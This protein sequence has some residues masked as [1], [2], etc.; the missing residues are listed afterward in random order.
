MANNEGRPPLGERVAKLALVHSVAGVGPQ[1]AGPPAN[2]VGI[3]TIR[4]ILVDAGAQLREL[5]A[6]GNPYAGAALAGLRRD[7]RKPALWYCAE[8]DHGVETK[9]PDVQDG[10]APCGFCLGRFAVAGAGTPQFALALRVVAERRVG[11]ARAAVIIDLEI[12]AENEQAARRSHLKLLAPFTEETTGRPAGE[13]EVEP[14]V[15]AAP[16]REKTT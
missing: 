6:E 16:Q 2:H 10:S 14:S 9:P 13:E 7:A 5:Q 1:A 8:G 12:R 11:G 4:E 15:K 3:P